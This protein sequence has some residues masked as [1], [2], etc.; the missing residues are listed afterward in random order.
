MHWRLGL[1]LPLARAIIYPL[2]DT[3]PFLTTQGRQLDWSQG[4]DALAVAGS[5]LVRVNRRG[6]VM[7]AAHWSLRDL[8]QLGWQVSTCLPGGH[9]LCQTSNTS[10]VFPT[11]PPRFAARHRPSELKC[12]RESS[13]RVLD[14]DWHYDISSCDVLDGGGDVVVYQHRVAY[15]DTGISTFQYWLLCIL[16]VFVVRSF[17]Y[18]IQSQ[19][20][21][22]KRNDTWYGFT[23]DQITVLAC[24]LSVILAISPD[25]IS[26]LVT[27]EDL[28][29][30]SFFVIYAAVY[31][32]AYGV[33]RHD[34][35]APLYNL[36]AATLQLTAS[37]LYKGVETP[38]AP[39]LLYVIITRCLIK[40]RSPWNLI[41]AITV[42]C[43]CMLISLLC[44]FGFPYQ[45]IYIIIVTI[46][47]FATVDLFIKV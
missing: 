31:I 42:A 22:Q 5:S 6:V 21:S 8:E 18:R 33:H 14:H 11:D 13:K 35:K 43:D 10:R 39:V 47:A 4:P 36:I 2:D 46:M 24:A 1:L 19:L 40:V 12:T 26:Q 23:N 16:A 15:K 29:C 9:A 20:D 32:L 28:L 38:F 30:C 45:P 25:F 37:R 27:W 17:S 44:V 41:Q 3:V 7:K 34:P